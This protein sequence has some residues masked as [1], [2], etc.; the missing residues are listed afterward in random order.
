MPENCVVAADITLISLPVTNFN[1]FRFPS[2]ILN[3]QVQEVSDTA[4][5]GTTEKFAKIGKAELTKRVRGIHH[6]K[7]WYFCPF[8][9]GF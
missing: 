2:A 8:L 6:E 4:G 9:W 3:L 1:Y 5:V 7:S